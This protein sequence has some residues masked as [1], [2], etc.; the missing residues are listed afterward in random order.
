MDIPGVPDKIKFI[1]ACSFSKNDTFK[2]IM[3]AQVSFKASATLIFKLQD[4]EKCGANHS[5][6]PSSQ[7]SKRSHEMD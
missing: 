4:Q 5:D 7:D 6:D 2:D 3:K 1:T